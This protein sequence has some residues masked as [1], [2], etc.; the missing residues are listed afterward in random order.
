MQHPTLLSLHSFFLLSLGL[1]HGEKQSY[2]TLHALLRA[3]GGQGYPI[4]LQHTE[5]AEG[6]QECIPHRAVPIRALPGP[7]VPWSH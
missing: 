5:R 4:L 3:Q 6:M 2:H 1:H 7:R